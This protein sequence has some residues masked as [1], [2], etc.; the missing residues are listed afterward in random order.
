MDESTQIAYAEIFEILKNM[1][2]NIV[3]KIPIDI[4]ET[5]NKYKKTNYVSNIDKDDIFN[6]NNISPKTLNILAWLNL[7]YFCTEKERADLIKIYRN[8]DYTAE[9]IKSEK[10]KIE[11]LFKNNKAEHFETNVELIPVPKKTFIQK[12]FDKIKSFFTMNHT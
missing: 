9:K 11:D 6:K 8:N 1:D 5:F 3:M 12:I 4:V 7:N 10:Y 2:R